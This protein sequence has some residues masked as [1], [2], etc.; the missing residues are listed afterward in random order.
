[1][2]DLGK[3]EADCGKKMQEIDQLIGNNTQ[4]TEN[5]SGNKIV[6]GETISDLV[7][8]ADTEVI[9]GGKVLF[10]SGDISL[11]DLKLR[12]KKHS[13]T[14]NDWFIACVTIAVKKYHEN[15]SVDGKVPQSNLRCETIF[16]TH[17]NENLNKFEPSNKVIGG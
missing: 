6:P 16:S 1:M 2:D 9:K 11:A 15:T 5:S 13:V 12:S 4:K 10:V 17:V 7:K 14:I 3:Q 8:E